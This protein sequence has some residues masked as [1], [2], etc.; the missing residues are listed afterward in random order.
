MIAGVFDAP[1]LFAF[2]STNETTNATFLTGGRDPMASA[3]PV[4]SRGGGGR[5]YPEGSSRSCPESPLLPT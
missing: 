2:S 5:R 4:G 1:A 3:A